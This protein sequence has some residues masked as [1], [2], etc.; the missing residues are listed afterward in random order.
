MSIIESI[1][2]RHSVRSYTGEALSKEHAECIE[3]YIA[4]LK[5]PFGPQACIR[6]IHTDTPTG[7]VKLGTY[8][9]I[10]GARNFLTLAYKKEP[11]AEESAAY[12]FEQVV[13]YCTSMELGTCWLGGSFSRKDFGGQIDLQPGEKVGIVSPV[14][15]ASGKKRFWDILIGSEKHHTS[16]KSFGSLFFSG[17]FRTPLTEEAAGIYRQPLEMVRLAP[18]ANN[19]QPWRIILDSGVLHFYHQKSLGGFDAIDSGIALA[20]FGETCRELGIAGRFELFPSAA[21][22][23]GVTYSLSWIT[24]KEEQQS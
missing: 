15:Y 17:N 3:A 11:L 5:A 16:R 8:G 24:D 6:L 13:L 9:V 23:E 7:K 18:S 21:Q 4:G 12:L 1:L 14:G 10:G 19:F 22:Q 2:R 20:H